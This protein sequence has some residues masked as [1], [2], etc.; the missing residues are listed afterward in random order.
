MPR[1]KPL[2]TATRNAPRIDLSSAAA[3]SGRRFVPPPPKGVRL[4]EPIPRATQYRP[5]VDDAEAK[6][7]SP[8]PGATSRGSKFTPGAVSAAQAR[9]QG[10][11]AMPQ[12][13]D[14][15]D[16]PF[17]ELEEDI[18]E[19]E[20]PPTDHDVMQRVPALVAQA[21]T[22]TAAQENR[23]TQARAAAVADNALRLTKV[24]D[25]EID[26]LWDW[27]RQDEDRGA[28]FFGVAIQVS[29]A[30]HAQI[31][32][33]SVSANELI[34]SLHTPREHVGFV[35]IV[36]SPEENVGTLK[37]YLRPDYRQYNAKV[38][39]PVVDL[40]RQMLPAFRFAISVPPAFVPMYRAALTGFVEHTMFLG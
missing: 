18:A 29:V 19:I 40:A 23:A 3:G 2:P 17:D 27:L 10:L 24:S 38:L 1:R 14:D 25:E 39:M 4:A 8:L 9:M 16:L 5:P 12:P 32:G 30:L 20:E 33:I 7:L 26:H 35:H 11:G 36:K 21:A 13:E 31:N 28:A 22:H 6:A 15:V 37:L 34:R